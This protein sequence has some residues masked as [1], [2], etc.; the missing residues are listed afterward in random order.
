MKSMVYETPVTSDMEL[1]ARITEAAARVRN[2][3]GQFER[4]CESMPMRRRCET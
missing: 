3:P 4:I 2:I 1:I